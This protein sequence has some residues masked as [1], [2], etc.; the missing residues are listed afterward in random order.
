MLTKVISGGQTGADIAGL[1]TAKS[2][3]IETGGL[4]PFGFKAYDAC[5]PEYKELYGVE[6]HTSSSYVPRTRANVQ[7]SDGTI[8]LARDFQSAGEICTKKAIDQYGKPWFDYDLAFP[9]IPKIENSQCYKLIQAAIAWIEDSNIEVLNVAGNRQ[10]TP[11]VDSI[12]I[13]ERASLF[14]TELFK[15]LGHKEPQGCVTLQDSSDGSPE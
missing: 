11:M 7:N 1:K 13:E 5:H 12:D 4:M 9:W 15:G 3:G 6:A 10:R 14:L 2:F 8:R